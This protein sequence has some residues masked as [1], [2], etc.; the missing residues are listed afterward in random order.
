M[1]QAA[2]RHL[3]VR[4]VASRAE[5]TAIRPHAIDVVLSAQSFHWF[6]AAPALVECARVLK[7]HGRLAI[8]WNRRSRTDPLTEGYRRAIADVGGESSIE[9]MAF[10][11]EV[12]RRSGIFT[13][14]ERA[15]FPNA[16]RLDLDGLIGRARSASY[17]PKDGPA[18]ARLRALLDDLWRTYADRDG[19]VTLVYETEVYRAQ[20]F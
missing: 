2:A 4:F 3:N 20:T 5:A 13:P 10:D 17:C 18:A 6:N 14:V 12:V 15:S 19:L 7:A 8:M 1:R 9:R 11:P 16:Q